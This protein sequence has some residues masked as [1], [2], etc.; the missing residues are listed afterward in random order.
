MEKIKNIVSLFKDGLL[1]VL[2]LLL[3]FL[4]TLFNRILERAGF[5]EGSIMGFTWKEKAIESKKVADSSQQLA[6]QAAARLD[7]MQQHL[8][9]ISEKLTVLPGS[10]A[11]DQISASI[12]SSKKRFNSYN[13]ELRKDVILQ[14]KKLTTI[15]Q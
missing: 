2:F 12:D 4:P 5:T 15:F 14:K 9:S 3:L 1:L 6:V 8:D 7:E 11:T 10:P 13:L